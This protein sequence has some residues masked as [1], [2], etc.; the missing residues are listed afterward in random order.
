M[1]RVFEE[2]GWKITGGNADRYEN[3]GVVKKATQKLLKTWKLKIDHSGGAVRVAEGRR[4][5]AGALSVKTVTK[6]Y[7][8]YDYLSSDKLKPAG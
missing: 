6:Q 7:Y 4:V 8:S 1:R 2:R 5:E 3:K